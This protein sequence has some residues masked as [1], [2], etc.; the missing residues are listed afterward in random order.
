MGRGDGERDRLEAF[1]GIIRDLRE[2]RRIYDEGAKGKEY[3][4]AV[5]SSFGRLADT[6]V[7]GR[8]GYVLDIK[9]LS[10]PLTQFLSNDPGENVD[11]TARSE[12]HNQAHGAGWIIQLRLL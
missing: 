3:R 8:A 1:R 10:K 11:G 4:V 7:A 12:C 2:Q 6:D 9:L 5:G